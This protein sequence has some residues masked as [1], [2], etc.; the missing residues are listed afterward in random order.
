VT[1]IPVR[2]LTVFLDF[3]AGVYER[4]RSFWTVRS[5]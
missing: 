4:E 3:R 5:G 1:A 2:W